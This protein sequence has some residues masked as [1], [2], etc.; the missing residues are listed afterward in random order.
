MEENPLLQRDVELHNLIG[1]LS[2]LMKEN[3]EAIRSL[4]LAMDLDPGFV[5]NYTD[6]AMIYFFEGDESA[7]LDLLDKAGRLDASYPGLKMVREM[8]KL[9][10]KQTKAKNL[11]RQGMMYLSVQD[12]KKARTLFRKALEMEPNNPFTHQW[13]AR[14]ERKL[15]LIA[16]SREHSRAYRKLSE[17]AEK[18]VLK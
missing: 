7:G 11:L 14:A 3:E 10:A 1:S 17:R 2:Y 16:S 18:V 12:F 9:M 8:W 5:K 15:G 13:L 6:L 4:K